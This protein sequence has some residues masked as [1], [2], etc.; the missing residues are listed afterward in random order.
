MWPVRLVGRADVASANL[1]EFAWQ[2]EQGDIQ[3]GI[4]AD[5]MGMGKTIQAISLIVTHCDES[6]KPEIIPFKPV[7]NK[8]LKKTRPKLGLRLR[9]RKT[10]S[11]NQSTAMDVD[12]AGCQSPGQS[13]QSLQIKYSVNELSSYV[14]LKFWAAIAFGVRFM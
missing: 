9:S 7:E 8:T 1:L 3:G 14:S 2:Q 5:E 11:A 13:S 12:T 6:F 4:L 10:D